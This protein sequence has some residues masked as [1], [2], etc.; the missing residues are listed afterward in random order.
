MSEDDGHYWQVQQEQEYLEAQDEQK[1]KDIK[2]EHSNV[3]TGKSRIREKHQSSESEP[4]RNI[5]DSDN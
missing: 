4:A 1:A 2:D 5:T 3:N